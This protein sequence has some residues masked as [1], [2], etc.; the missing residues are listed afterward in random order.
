MLWRPPIACWTRVCSKSNEI[1]P[2]VCPQRAHRFRCWFSAAT[3]RSALDCSVF[4]CYYSARAKDLLVHMF[5]LWLPINIYMWL[6]PKLGTHTPKYA[7]YTYILVHPTYTQS[8][9]MRRGVVGG[10]G[11][12][13]PSSEKRVA[14]HVNYYTLDVRWTRLTQSVCVCVCSGWRWVPHFCWVCACV[15]VHGVIELKFNIHVF[16]ALDPLR[17]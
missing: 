15:C 3:I 16:S 2:I 9:L 12:G 13:P 4:F 7:M 6:S 5:V 10:G 14:R 1:I 17:A 8:N 11:G